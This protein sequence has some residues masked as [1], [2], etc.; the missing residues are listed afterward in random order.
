VRPA[1]TTGHAAGAAALQT[2]AAPI[3]LAFQVV[4]DI[5]DVTQASAKLG[6]T[7]GKDAGRTTSPPTSPS[8][9]SERRARIRLA[10]ARRRPM[11]ALER[12]GA[13]GPGALALLGDIA[14]S[15]WSGEN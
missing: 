7:A 1:A 3:G 4:D 10:A 5:L 11:Q 15:W 6:K 9:A 8:W 14:D 12:S 13:G 2:T